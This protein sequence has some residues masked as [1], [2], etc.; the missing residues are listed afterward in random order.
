MHH[1]KSPSTLA[2]G[3]TSPPSIVVP[4][5]VIKSN[6]ITLIHPDPIRRYVLKGK[7]ISRV[8]F[9]EAERDRARGGDWLIP[10]FQRDEAGNPDLERLLQ[11][12]PGTRPSAGPFPPSAL[13]HLP[14][15]EGQRGRG[16]VGRRLSAS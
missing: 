5:G 7:T 16:V 13:E 6:S 8:N 12:L 9:V 1:F 11:P 14:T 4:G 2:C 10:P 3:N 15:W